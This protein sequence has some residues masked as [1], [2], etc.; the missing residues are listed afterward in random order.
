M[1][2]NILGSFS[3]VMDSLHLLQLGMLRLGDLKEGDYLELTENE[4]RV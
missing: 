4:I 3:L 2:L 1:A